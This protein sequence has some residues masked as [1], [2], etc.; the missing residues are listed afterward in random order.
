[1]VATRP[2]AKKVQLRGALVSASWIGDPIRRRR[3]TACSPDVHNVAPRMQWCFASAE[4]QPPPRP[5]T[6]V[7][8]TVASA[9]PAFHV[10]PRRSSSVIRC[11]GE[12]VCWRV[13]TSIEQRR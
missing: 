3:E 7:R 9:M 2:T 8:R 12:K 4:K 11:H 1:M 13:T 5:R 6:P 10:R